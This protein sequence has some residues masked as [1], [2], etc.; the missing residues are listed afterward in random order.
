MKKLKCI[1]MRV[2][3]LGAIF[4]LTSCGGEKWQVCE[5]VVVSNSDCESIVSDDKKE[6]IAEALEKK[7]KNVNLTVTDD[8]AKGLLKDDI[9]LEGEY[10]EAY[11]VRAE[12]LDSIFEVDGHTVETYINICCDEEFTFMEYEMYAQYDNNEDIYCFAE[13][14]FE[15]PSSEEK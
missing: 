11:M 7:Y 13:V 9:A 15:L 2:C 1:L 10:K 4:S 14:D 6:D 5:D 8:S 3:M 12:E